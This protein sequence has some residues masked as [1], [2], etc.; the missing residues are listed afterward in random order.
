MAH[1]HLVLQLEE[2]GV[3]RLLGKRGEGERR[4]ELGTG[5]GQHTADAMSALAKQPDKLARLVGRDAAA[6][7]Q[8]DPLAAHGR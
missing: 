8:E 4:D 2:R 1:L 7:D 6:D 3:D 5:L